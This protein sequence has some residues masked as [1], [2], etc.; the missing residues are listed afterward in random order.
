MHHRKTAWSMLPV[1][2]V[3]ALTTAPTAW[4]QPTSDHL[5]CYKIKDTQAKKSYTADLTGLTAEPGCTIKVPAVQLCVETTKTGVVPMPPESGPTSPPAG[6]FLCYKLK[7]PKAALAPVMVNDQFGSRMVMPGA[8]KLLCAPER[9]T[10]STASTTSS[11]TS[12]STTTTSSM[13]GS[14]STTTTTAPS[15]PNGVCEPA[16]GEDCTTCPQDCG[17]CPTT[18]SSSTIVL[19]GCGDSVCD[20]GA[21]E[22]CETCP[23]D[24]G[25]GAGTYC[26]RSACFP[27]SPPF[28]NS[29]TNTTCT[30]TT[31]TSTSTTTLP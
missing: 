25:C 4:A 10:S 26:Y 3:L 23:Q 7:C 22:N 12:S 5:K 24:C 28:C 9:S 30:S 14:S 19:P 31:T 2:T 11:T 17:T 15:C 27:N 13:T 8:P 21:G 16:L 20:N 1:A 29:V 18:T 6:E